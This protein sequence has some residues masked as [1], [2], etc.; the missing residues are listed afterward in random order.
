MWVLRISI[1]KV[2]M[3]RAFGCE[4]K[5]GVLF[6]WTIKSLFHFVFVNFEVPVYR[7]FDFA[8]S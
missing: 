2:G 5:A 6:F 4:F 8:L 3:A 1:G 7:S